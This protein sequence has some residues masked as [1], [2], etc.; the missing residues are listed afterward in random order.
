[1][2]QMVQH[3]NIP[4]GGLIIAKRNQACSCDDDDDDK[5]ESLIEKFGG[6]RLIL[7]RIESKQHC[8]FE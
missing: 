8:C 5:L 3:E 6:E 4:C 7:I 1:M 2:V